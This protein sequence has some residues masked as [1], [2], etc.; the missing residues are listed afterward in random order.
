MKRVLAGALATIVL[1]LLPAPV[2]AKEAK[3]PSPGDAKALAASLAARL[4]GRTV[5]LPDGKEETVFGPPGAWLTTERVATCVETMFE[6]DGWPSS[7]LVVQDASRPNDLVIHVV[8]GEDGAVAPPDVM[9]AAPRREWDAEAVEA[10]VKAATGKKPPREKTRSVVVQSFTTRVVTTYVYQPSKAA[11]EKGS[12]ASLLP[13]GAILRDARSVDL[14][15]GERHTLALVLFDAR[16]LPT[17]CVSCEARLFGHADAAKKVELVLAGE[18]GLE[19]TLDITSHLKGKGDG[20]LV[21]RFDCRE[22]DRAEAEAGRSYDERFG[23]REPTRILNLADHNGDGRA[24]EFSLPAEFLDCGR[25]T[26]LV[27]GV[28]P[29]TRKLRVLFERVDR[30][31]TR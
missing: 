11:K 17:D 28:D 30:E 26:S 2:A 20:P 6:A 7:W 25:H 21:P 5:R 18:K 22:G 19:D 12:L 10:A 31:P 13:E 16:F 23:S 9:F 27:A 15:D 8:L 29:E 4:E 3:R 24:L 1:V 14:G